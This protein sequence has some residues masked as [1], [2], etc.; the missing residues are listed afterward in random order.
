AYR[1]LDLRTLCARSCGRHPPE[2]RISAG[3]PPY[4]LSHGGEEQRACRTLARDK[5]GGPARRER[6]R[7]R[8]ARWRNAYFVQ[9]PCWAH[10]ATGQRGRGASSPGSSD[11]QKAFF[12]RPTTICQVGVSGS[13]IGPERSARV[14]TWSRDR[15]SSTEPATPTI[16]S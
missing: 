16:A 6:E 1:L 3:M 8:H 12:S 13:S 10:A 9:T 2:C 7:C 11:R 4:F 5:R 14:A 15:F